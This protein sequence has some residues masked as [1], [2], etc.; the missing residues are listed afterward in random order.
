MNKQSQ[1]SKQSGF[2]DNMIW[3]LKRQSS[4]A[5]VISN[6][7][8]QG[9]EEVGDSCENEQQFYCC[10]VPSVQRFALYV[11]K[12]KC[13]ENLTDCGVNKQFFFFFKLTDFTVHSF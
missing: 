2:P 7:G 5:P 9:L 11:Q 1:R 6:H 13:N 10:F 3:R 4:N 8:P 12:W